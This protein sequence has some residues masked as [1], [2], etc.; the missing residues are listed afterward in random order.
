MTQKVS[1]ELLTAIK[2]GSYKL[3]PVT[4]DQV[5]K[6]DD[7]EGIAKLF[8][9]REAVL[10]QELGTAIARGLK[11]KKSLY[12][13][14]MHEQSDTIQALA[15]AYGE[16]M[17]VEQCIAGIKKVAAVAKPLLTNICLVSALHSLE[18]DLSFFLTR[19]LL[20]LDAGKQ[21]S[22]QL[23]KMIEVIGGSCQQALTLVEAFG[24]P[25]EILHAPL[26]GDWAK[27][28][29]TDNQGELIASKL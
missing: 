10:A 14:W 2:D 24:I 20:T 23:N 6:F 21:V 1:K 13:V 7:L 5:F 22:A 26:A 27:Y 29:E 16:N 8:K 3:V 25:E 9:A 12:S 11:E 15:R 28:N 17:V 19:K 18:S 4:K